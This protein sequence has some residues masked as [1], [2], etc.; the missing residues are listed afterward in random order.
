MKAIPEAYVYEQSTQQAFYFV[1]SAS[2]DG[3][4]LDTEDIIIAYNGSVIVGARYWYGE[5]TDVP[6]MGYDSEWNPK[7][8]AG[9]MENGQMPTFRLFRAEDGSLNNMDVLN[10]FEILFI[11]IMLKKIKMTINN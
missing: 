8:T 10:D 11:C 7:G 5:V 2:I 3:E 4:L 6:V 1:E 9:Y